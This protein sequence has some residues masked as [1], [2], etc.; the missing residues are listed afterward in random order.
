MDLL[1]IL[2]AIIGIS[3]SIANKKKNMEAQKK[4]SAF[5]EN[6]KPASGSGTAR[7]AQNRPAASRTSTTTKSTTLPKTASAPGT[8]KWPWSA[9]NTAQPQK[10]N[11]NSD[12]SGTPRY[13]HVVTSTLEGGHTHT[14]SSMTGEEACPPPKAAMQK[15]TAEKAPAANAATGGLISFQ[16]NN[17]L[18]GVLYAEILGKPK[19]LQRK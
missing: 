12:Y 4:R 10:K 13:S 15:Q 1:M 11:T 16:P 14:E 17:V 7:S 6:G 3:A 9:Q 19:A 8:S 18:Q 5:P 2:I